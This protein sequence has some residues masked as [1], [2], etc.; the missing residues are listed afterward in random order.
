MNK[1]IKRK[2]GQQTVFL[3]LIVS[4]SNGMTYKLFN[5]EV[6]ES[7]LKLILLHFLMFGF[8]YLFSYFGYKTAIR[9]GQIKDE[10]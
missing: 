2:I 8:C 5:P 9:K 4:A 1:G 6:K 7:N 3:F 10:G